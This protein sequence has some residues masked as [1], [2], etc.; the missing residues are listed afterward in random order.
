MY[1]LQDIIIPVRIRLVSSVPPELIPCL[2]PT[3]ARDVRTITA[4]LRVLE[5]VVQ[6]VHTP[7]QGALTV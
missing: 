2:E 4:H 6:R 1:Y 5:P 7:L 3:L